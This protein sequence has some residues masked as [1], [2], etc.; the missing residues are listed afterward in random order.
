M[1]ASPAQPAPSESQRR[2]SAPR[3]SLTEVLRLA[4]SAPGATTMTMVW[5]LVS[6]GAALLIPTVSA[7]AI[8]DAVAGGTPGPALAVLTVLLA[9]HVLAEACS[10]LARASAAAQVA[11]GSPGSIRPNRPGTC[12][13][14][15][16]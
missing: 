13:Q 10:G 14:V 11:P 9:L 6:V 3:M 16:W 15:V 7:Q 5:G 2:G 4:R 12:V 8:D 1:S